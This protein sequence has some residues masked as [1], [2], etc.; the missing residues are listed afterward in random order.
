MKFVSL[1]LEFIKVLSSR[2]FD[3]KKPLDFTVVPEVSDDCHRD[4]VQY[5][6]ALK[7]FELWALKSE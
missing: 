1:L 7:T 5:L 3:Y 4:F 6:S 2:L